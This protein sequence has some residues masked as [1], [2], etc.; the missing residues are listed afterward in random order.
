MGRIRQVTA[1][2]VADLD[3]LIWRII[4]AL[5]GHRKGGGT[6][7][8]AAGSSGRFRVWRPIGEL[9]PIAPRIVLMMLNLKLGS[10]TSVTFAHLERPPAPG[11]SGAAAAVTPRRRVGQFLPRTLGPRAITQRGGRA[12]VLGRIVV[13]CICGWRNAA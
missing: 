9:R 13:T 2:Q 11:S 8:F 12:V 1:H 7:T 10:D 3:P 5:A 6:G 4:F